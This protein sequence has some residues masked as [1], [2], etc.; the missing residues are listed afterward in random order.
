LLLVANIF[1]V[2][3]SYD[4]SIGIHYEV[5]HLEIFQEQAV[6]SVTCCA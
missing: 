2:T 4:P 6:K 1:I 5:W 3:T